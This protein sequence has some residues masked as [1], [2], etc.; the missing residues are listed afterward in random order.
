[1]S[2]SR[3]L[4]FCTFV[5]LRRKNS[6]SSFSISRNGS[7]SGKK[8]WTS[9]LPPVESILK[10]IKCFFVRNVNKSSFLKKIRVFLDQQERFRAFRKAGDI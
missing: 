5:Q 6:T 7:H 8:D 1:M 10:R 4:L 2:G 9:V 3:E